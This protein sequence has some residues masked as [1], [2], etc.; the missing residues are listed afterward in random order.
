M[1]HRVDYEE[2][3]EVNRFEQQLRMGSKFRYTQASTR[4]RERGKGFLSF[5]YFPNHRYIIL[6]CYT[7]RVSAIFIWK[8]KLRFLV[9]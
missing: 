4:Y 1:D 5:V 6:L 7:T 2:H 3:M 9:R 8:S